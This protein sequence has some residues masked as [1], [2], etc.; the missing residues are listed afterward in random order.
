MHEFEREGMIDSLRCRR[1]DSMSYVAPGAE[2]K[3]RARDLVDIHWKLTGIETPSVSHNRVMSCI[4][5]HANPNTGRCQVKQK[6]IAAETGY[7]PKTV[8]RAADWWVSQSFLI[9]QDMGL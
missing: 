8:R 1:G 2:Q 4:I 9:V 6:L 7:S 3:W 5:G